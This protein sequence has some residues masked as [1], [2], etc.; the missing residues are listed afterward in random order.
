[1]NKNCKSYYQP[2]A[3]A[4]Y[5]S[6][7]RVETLADLALIK[8]PMSTSSSLPPGLMPHIKKCRVRGCKNNFYVSLSSSSSS[9]LRQRWCVKCRVCKL[10]RR[11]VY[12]FKKIWD[13]IHSKRRLVRYCEPCNKKNLNIGK[14][15]VCVACCRIKKEFYKVRYIKHP[16]AK[17]RQVCIDCICKHHADCAYCGCS[18]ALKCKNDAVEANIDGDNEN[19]DP[20]I[21]S[22]VHKRVDLTQ[23]CYPCYDGSAFV[24]CDRCFCYSDDLK[25]CMCKCCVRRV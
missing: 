1:M 6:H 14:S 8:V 19:Y 3:L 21:V 13:P 18:L 22:F 7:R 9:L 16:V 24:R 15:V 20:A 12:K 11:A 17:E 5:R 4:L 23:L 10:C 2:S 25:E